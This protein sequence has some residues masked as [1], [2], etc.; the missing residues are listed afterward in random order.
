MLAGM[1]ER[2]V[3]TIG[4]FDGVHL[5]HQ[6][7]LRQA[8]DVARGPDARVIA[9]TF[10]PHPIEVLKPNAAPPRLMSRSDKTHALRE[11]GADNVRVIEPA[12]DW[13]SQ[14]PET[15]VET[16]VKEHQPIA[17]VEGPDFRFGKDR[18]G[19]IHT[20]RSLGKRM[21][22]DVHQV[23]RVE[24]SL[25]NQLVAGVSSTLVRWLLAHGRAADAA[26]C[27]GR[28]FSLSGTIIQG[29]G[30]GKA[31][32]VPTANIDRDA[33]TGYAMPAF[34]VYAGWVTLE[35]QPE[36]GLYAAAIN[37]GAK[38]TFEEYKPTVEAH[39]LDF[40]QDLYTRKIRVH[41]CR[42][43]RDQQPFP[44]VEHLRT[45]LHRDIDQVN[46]WRGMGKL[47]LAGIAGVLGDSRGSGDSGGSGCGDNATPQRHKR[48]RVGS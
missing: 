28:P 38:P 34:G 29:Q 10:D 48:S 27:L 8:V 3:L 21:G 42:W 6:A 31:I 39:L 14:S 44:S 9:L 36:S 2:C 45:Q 4:N 43:I 26:A 12:L 18:T 13:L 16:M 33:M 19:D 41:F 22:F 20:L 24:I 46:R 37:A 7:I 32:G 17:V 25:G 47:E 15:F 30:R 11:A 40:D 35:D 23:D 1:G 5:G